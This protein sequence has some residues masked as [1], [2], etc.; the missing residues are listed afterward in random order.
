MQCVHVNWSDGDRIVVLV[1]CGPKNP[2][3]CFLKVRMAILC[4]LDF[5]TYL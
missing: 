3:N 2:N 4:M 1:L 5:I